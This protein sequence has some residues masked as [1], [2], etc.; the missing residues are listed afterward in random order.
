MNNKFLFLLILIILIFSIGLFAQVPQE[1]NYQGFLT[2]SGVP[3]NGTRDLRFRIYDDPDPASATLVWDSDWIINQVNVVDGLYTYKLGSTTG[4]PVFS[5]IDWTSGERYLFLL[6][7]VR[8]ANGTGD[9]THITPLT[10]IVSVPFALVAR[11][12]QNRPYVFVD[13]GGS[14]DFTDIQNAIDSLGPEGGTIYIKSGNYDL[15]DTIYINKNNIEIIGIGVNRPRILADINFDGGKTVIDISRSFITIKNVVIE[16]KN[17]AMD[18]GI[19]IHNANYVEIKNC[20]IATFYGISATSCNFFKINNCNID[21]IYSPLSISGNNNRIINNLVRGG[22]ALGLIASGNHLI[23][24]NNNFS[25]GGIALIVVD[26]SYSA[27]RNNTAGSGGPAVSIGSCF[28][29]V[30]SGNICRSGFADGIAIIS[31]DNVIVSGNVCNNNG[32]DGIF[33]DSPTVSIIGNSCNNNGSGSQGGH[34]IYSVAG[35]IVTGNTATGNFS[36]PLGEDSP[37]SVKG[38]CN[39]WNIETAKEGD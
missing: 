34:G 32:I 7:T 24:D 23:I 22:A 20:A 37:Y 39:S 25:A 4:F 1:V 19:E 16:R 35:S 6:V 13:A 26:S 10:K 30:I 28:S 17:G 33:N 12:V 11:D 8:E 29:L 15:S 38:G 36:G 3:V 5:E 27:I 2:D 31:S 14:G 21:A 9:G 18:G